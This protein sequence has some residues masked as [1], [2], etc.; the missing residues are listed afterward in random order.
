MK[1]RDDNLAVPGADRALRLRHTQEYMR[2]ADSDRWFHRVMLFMLAPVLAVCNDARPESLGVPQQAGGEGRDPDDLPAVEEAPVAEPQETMTLVR[3][4]AAAYERRAVAAY[5]LQTRY[6]ETLPAEP[7][8]EDR[9][10]QESLAEKT[11]IGSGGDNAFYITGSGTRTV[12]DPF[13]MGTLD[14][15][16]VQGMDST[17]GAGHSSCDRLLITRVG[18]PGAPGTLCVLLLAA[19]YGLP[20]GPVQAQSAVS[21][22]PVT[23]EVS[24]GEIA[25][26]AVNIDPPSALPLTV[27]YTPGT[28]SDSTTV[29]ATR[30]D[31]ANDS[32]LRIAAGASSGVIAIP[33][34]A[35]DVVESA[36]EV[37]TITLDTPELTAGYTLGSPV[38]TVIT[39][40]AEGTVTDGVCDRTSQVRDWIVR[41]APVDSCMDVTAEHLILPGEGIELE[42]QGITALKAGDFHGIEVEGLFLDDNQLTSL[43]AG[44]FNGLSL[45]RDLDLSGNQLTSLPTGVF[46]GL[47]VGRDLDLS[48]NQLTSL[49]TGVFDGLSLASLILS[50]NKLTSLPEDVFDGLSLKVGLDLTDNQLTSLPEDVFDGLSL[51]YLA[52]SRNQLTSLPAGI[53]DGLSLRDSLHLSGNQLTSLLTGTF[54]GLSVRYDL[55]L[56]DNKLTSLPED[57][58][59]GLS[60]GRGLYLTDNQL[61]SLPTGVFDGLSLGRELD[62]SGNQLTSLLTGTFDGLS[63]ASLIL[64]DNQLTSLPTDVFDGLS[65]EKRLDLSGNQLTSLLTGTF[66]G[67]NLLCNLDL[68]GNQLT[69]L[70]TGVFNGL[71]LGFCLGLHSFIFY[72]LDLSGNQL[73]S[74][75]T[76]VFD[77]LSVR[78]DLILTDNIGAPF[79]LT[80][81][82]ERT[83]SA[84]SAAS[85]AEVVLRLV[86][87][88]PHTITVPVTVSSGGALSSSEATITA[89][90]TVS[91]T[92]TVTGSG[93]VIVALGKL[94]GFPPEYQGLQLLGGT[95]LVLFRAAAIKASISVPGA[96]SVEESAGTIDIPVA[97]DLAVTHNTMVTYTVTAE[98]AGLSDYTAAGSSMINR[99]VTEAAIPITITDDALFEGEETFTVTLTGAISEVNNVIISPSAA[100]T[101][102][103]IN[104][105]VND[106]I[107][108]SL[109]GPA[110]VRE[111]D[112]VTYT[113]TLTGGTSTAV[114]MVSY[115]LS[116]GSPADYTDVT[117]GTLTLAAGQSQGEIMVQA[118]EDD[119]DPGEVLTVTLG[120]ISG[121]GGP[122]ASLTVGT[123]QLSTTITESAEVVEVALLS[124]P[125]SIT[126]DAYGAGEQII[127]RV[128]FSEAVQLGGTETPRLVLG[129]GTEEGACHSG[130]RKQ[131]GDRAGVCVSGGHKGYRRGWSEYCGR[132]AGPRQCHLGGYERSRSEH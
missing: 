65:L 91:E 76:G 59:D 32:S 117:G 3:V 106:A 15:P 68:S 7:P 98:T 66:D 41:H 109:S 2:H 131:H 46:N 11:L 114:V 103:T 16:A 37:F 72:N 104:A 8:G 125:R 61:T 5:A 64:S 29:D 45:G 18:I 49:P 108:A 94:P 35:D 42:N 39:I 130:W 12:L 87:G 84:L 79:S 13:G 50:D 51:A 43:P 112:T 118:V 107:I 121:G 89:G 22:S 62:L 10:R 19:L 99:G 44:A 105:D 129:V 57:V 93:E 28:D 100:S 40:V 82:L 60:V 69:S 21:L 127:V 83:G 90:S 47:S 1:E 24:E 14:L 81:E 96:L 23:L 6:L 27:H 73:A 74:L 101:T 20:I 95:P 58:F 36:P 123:G 113:V 70:P 26:V 55:I 48:G 120:T 33:I 128:R 71:S 31:Y 54:D 9:N 77:G 63:L 92:F 116:G 132:C 122:A 119:S 78:H 126:R 38:T 97:A 110:N 124:I 30:A 86:E 53:F 52:L 75:P 25:S 56:T 34:L 102:V 17:M 115:S 111:G 88:T 67:L 85:P 80:V 4:R